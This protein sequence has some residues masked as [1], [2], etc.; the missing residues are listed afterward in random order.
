ML[1]LMRWTDRKHGTPC[2]E[3]LHSSVGP[4]RPY[5]AKQAPVV[6]CDRIDT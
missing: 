2:I 3:V 1:V 4:I 6:L 5:G